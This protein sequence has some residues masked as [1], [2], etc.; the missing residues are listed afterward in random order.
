[1]ARSPCALVQPLIV[2]Q[3]IVFFMFYVVII[4][5]CLCDM[6]ERKHVCHAC[7]CRSEDNLIALTL[8]LSDVG[9]GDQASVRL[10]LPTE[11]SS[12]SEM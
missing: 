2:K 11:P 9:F 1:M 3:G 6:G 7:V 5:V 10:A 4:I 12:K 8:S